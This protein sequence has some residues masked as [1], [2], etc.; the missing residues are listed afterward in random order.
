M[1]GVLHGRG[2]VCCLTW[3]M[4]SRAAYSWVLT[5]HYPETFLGF[6][7]GE[8]LWWEVSLRRRDKV[9]GHVEIVWGML[10]RI[11]YRK[12]MSTTVGSEQ[13]RID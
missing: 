12:Q 13:K 4:S 8:L 3:T 1:L 6:H 11:F 10:L 9:T 7:L 5:T 2:R